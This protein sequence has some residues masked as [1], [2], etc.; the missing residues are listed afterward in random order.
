[1][2]KIV[3]IDYKLGNTLSLQRALSYLNFKSEVTN[4]KKKILEADKIILPG[5]GAF[6]TAM[7][8]L[9]LFDLIDVLKEFV[10]KGNDILGICLGMQL[11]MNSSDEFQYTKGLSLI[12]GT[13]EIISKKKPIVKLPSIGWFEIKKEKNRII[14]KI[15]GYHRCY[16]VH[17]YKVNCIDKNLILAKYNY[18]NIEIIAAIRDK[19]IF[20]VQILNWY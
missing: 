7:N 13:V 18:G 9:K 16:V 12:E 14:C 4:D 11:L 5:V 10:K 17:S 1:M 6:P 20:G 19:N 15:T 2:K 8:Y 3:I